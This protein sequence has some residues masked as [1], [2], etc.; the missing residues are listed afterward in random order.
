MDIS[1]IAMYLL[2]SL[3]LFFI[4]LSDSDLGDAALAIGL[5]GI[6]SLAVGLCCLQQ[7]IVRLKAAQVL[8]QKDKYRASANAT[9]QIESA[10]SEA[11]LSKQMD[12]HHAI[13][14]AIP[15][16]IMRV[17]RAGIHLEFLASPNFGI[18]GNLAELAGTHITDLFPPEAAA[19]RLAAIERALEMQQMQIYKQRL[20]VAGQIQIEEVRVVPYSEDE[21]VLLVRD[22]SDRARAEEALRQNQAQSQAMLSAIPDLMFRVGADG[23]YRGEISHPK[24]F[25]VVPL[26]IKLT[27]RSISEVWPAPLAEQQMRYLR[28]ALAT[29]EMQ[30]YEQAIQRSYCLQHEEVRVVKT[31]KDEVLFII[32]DVTDRKRAETTLQNLIAGTA[33]TTGED[34]FPVLV[35]H[36]AR[37]LDVSHAFVTEKLGDRL[38]TLAFWDDGTLASNMAYLIEKTPC[39]ETLRR[40]KFYC[41]SS[42]Q[43]AFPEDQDL[44]DLRVESYFGI[45]LKNQQGDTIG[46][47][48]I[49]NRQ[50]IPNLQGAE[51]IL[52]TFGARAAAELERQRASNALE[53][54]NQTLEFRV[55]E[56]T[57]ALRE[58]EQFL[59]TLLDTFPLAIFWKDSNSGFLGANQ[60]FLH[61]FGFEHLADL[62]GKTEYDLSS[63]SDP[64]I[65]IAEDRA[66]MASGT[67]EIGVVEQKIQPDGTAVWLERNK[68]PLYDC[69]GEIVGVLGTY[70][71]ISD[72][73]RAEAQ[74]QH[75]IEGTATTLG[76]DFFPA[77][78]SHIAETL[79]VAYA[80]VTERTGAQLK[81]LGFWADGT[82]RPNFVYDSAHT[83][84]QQSMENG[85]LYC[86]SAVQQKFASGL[87]LSEMGAESYL[88]VALQDCQGQAIGNL[89]VFSRQV[90]SHPE[91]AAQILRVFAARAAAEL[92]RQRA[93]TLLEQL[94]ASLEAKVTKRTTRLREREQ[95]LKTLLDTLPL[96]VF[97]K[98]INSVFLGCN[99]QFAQFLTLPSQ[100]EIVGKTDFDVVYD[101][102]EAIAFRNS[103]RQVI[104]S[105]Q[106]YLTIEESLTLP[107][108]EQRWLSTSKTPLR[109]SVGNIIGIVGIFQDITSLKATQ[110]QL[111][112]NML[113]DPLTELPNRALL[114]ERLELAIQKSQRSADY[115]YAVLFLD[116][117][118]FKVINDSLGH[119]IG[120]KLLI[121]IAQRLSRHLRAV[122]L[123]ARLGGDE[124]VVL[125]ENISS[126]NE[127]VHT[128][129]RILADGAQPLIIEGHTIVTSFSIGIATDK[130]PY[131]QAT[132]LIRDADIAMYRAKS[133][134][135]NSYQ[136]FDANMHAQALKRLTLES[137]IRQGLQRNEF[138][139]YY[140][141]V[142]ALTHNQL[143]GFEALVRWHHPKKG[144]IPPSEFISI[145]EE[146]GLITSLDYWVFKQACHQMID[147]QARYCQGTPLRLSVNLSV[148]DLRD[149]TL[150][151]NID[152]VLAETKISPDLI[153]FEITES[154]IINDIDQTIELLEKIRQR[155]I[156]ISLDDFGTGYSSLSYLHRLPVNALK[157]DS[158]FVKQ[159]HLEDRNCQ[160]VQT[161]IALGHQM[162]IAAI[163]E[164]IENAQQLEQLKALGCQW[165]Q[166]YWFARP[167]TQEQTAVW[168]QAN[169]HLVLS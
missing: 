123:V 23:I 163:A 156:Q 32:R 57:A 18:L 121:A 132:D 112:H 31:G 131:K 166:G 45:A 17:N 29:G 124:F 106:S 115:H 128:A 157:I 146:T 79:N 30:V 56:R 68:V 161:I 38:Q 69:D 20:S 108:A 75:L 28:Q 52:L 125:L 149:V 84:C 92:E 148:Q 50:P 62:I 89:C 127:A 81:T 152:S 154:M 39:E 44:V 12:H 54:I 48:C 10:F 100:A 91:R 95:F 41:E 2:G 14:A 142:L 150:I 136:I 76:R 116:L 133:K 122:D 47:L 7:G 98:D 26:D 21:V 40:G 145:A 42:V 16:L 13:L 96:A 97:W 5:G 65:Y 105:G 164:G 111:V 27:G 3:F 77:L 135:Q 55:V 130:T 1:I 35:Q 160:L 147:W 9:P 59:R 58:Q 8:N 129:E 155:Q 159:M 151:E 118:R 167:L 99:R 102:A 139:I 138:T 114:T 119:F 113:H 110:A 87:D 46:N 74:L 143:L 67:S 51:Q 104:A 53:Q 15:D 24:E 80:I 144:L 72:R 103:D 25:A 93:T 73:K 4:R 43:S 78:V 11:A 137:E 64:E 85:Y 37:T 126:V 169:Q 165:G 34:F 63:I 60:H 107:D 66:V 71:D 49:L 86:E 33:A 162:G 36:V 6:A 168:L 153:T 82:L 120:D 141:P 70:Q 83:P 109:D 94:N 117:D 158:S 140:Q 90:I 88:G 61:D 19:Q 134:K 101:R 22:I